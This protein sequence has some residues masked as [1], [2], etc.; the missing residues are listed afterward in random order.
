MNS[1]EKFREVVWAAITTAAAAGAEADQLHGVLLELA[2]LD[3][4]A[5]RDT[6]EGLD[7]L[8]DGDEDDLGTQ[9]ALARELLRRVAGDATRP[10]QEEP[11]ARDVPVRAAGRPS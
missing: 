1:I 9:L 2:S 10:M 11:T 7:G 3:R 6:A 8:I 5:A 4:A